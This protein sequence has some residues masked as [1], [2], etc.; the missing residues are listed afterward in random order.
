V[1]LFNP[2]MVILGGVLRLVFP[3]VRD[4]VL[5]ALHTWAL[6][7]PAE[8]AQ[9]VLPS[10][11]GDSVIIGAAELAFTD[12]LHDP[13]RVLAEADGAVAAMAGA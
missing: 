6:D 13:L 5:A 1:N 3:L 4:D 8:Q 10:L 7:A 2:E 11:G 12:L 9:I